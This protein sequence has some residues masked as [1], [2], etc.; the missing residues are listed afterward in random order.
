LSSSLTRRIACAVLCALCACSK[1]ADTGSAP[2]SVTGR[3][4]WT[5]AG[6][7]RIGIQT[8]P[9]TL[10]PLLAGNTTEAM[11][12]RLMFDPLVT[13]DAS[14]KNEIPVLAQTVPSLANG[15]I[16]RDGLTITYHLRRNVR[17]QDGFPFTS[18]DVV[19]SIH[20]ILNPNNNVI[21]HTGYDLIRTMDTP[22]DHTVVLHM[23]KPYAPAI[24]TIFGESDSPFYVVP[25]HLLA[26]L[27]DINNIAWNSS[28]IGTGPYKFVRWE[29]GDHIDLVANPSYFLGKPKIEHITIKIVPDENT[30]A[31]QMRTHD[32]DWQFEASPDLYAT[33]KTIP[34]IRL[35]LQDRNEFE[36]FD[37]NVSHPP[38]DDVRVR[39]AISYAIDRAKLVHD[40]TG[41]SA[42]AADQDLPPF[43]WAHS[44]D[45]T[46]YTPD[47]VI[48]KA[49]LAQAGFTP[50]PD[51]ILTK[52]GK[53]LS[54]V[55]VTNVSNATRRSGVVQIQAMLRAVGIDVEVKT[56]DGGLLFRAYGQGGI[57]QTGRYDLSWTAW[58]SGI[59]PDNS[60]LVVCAARPPN[61]NNTS[62]YC[63]PALDAAEDDALTHFD[64][65]T[66]KKAYDRIESILTRDIPILPIWWPRQIQPVNPDLKNFTPNPVTTTWNAY[67]WD[68]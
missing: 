11:I 63:N 7:L 55:E 60:S 17:W 48:A 31:N 2:A 68:I 19:F 59:D 58:V 3:H 27:H 32:L 29:R 12:A 42:T 39:Q 41:G 61:G 30:E 65:P 38:L 51:G 4:P 52:N 24:N 66:R 43:M 9:T 8:Q 62:R 40:L 25:A 33:L 26:G 46:H 45:I 23:K 49:L 14:G 64:R 20:A 53:R 5:Q 16:S 50:G 15:G 37:M 22:D 34:D 13:V 35:V 56:Y 54:L 1:A 6:R 57:L 67:Q 44:R 21:S 36:R 28:P 47:L 18:H 10:D